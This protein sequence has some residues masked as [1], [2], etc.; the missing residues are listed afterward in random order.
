MVLLLVARPQRFPNVDL[1]LAHH[2]RGDH[3]RELLQLVLDDTAANAS[4]AAVSTAAPCICHSSWACRLP[5]RASSGKVL[6]ALPAANMYAVSSSRRVLVVLAGGRQPD[7]PPGA[8][9]RQR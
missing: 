7:R 2:G 5:R 4:L 6:L 3:R 1:K 9:R 8:R